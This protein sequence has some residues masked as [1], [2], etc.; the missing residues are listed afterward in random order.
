M[1]KTPSTSDLRVFLFMLSG[2]FL[3]LAL[4]SL[5]NGLPIRTWALV[6]ALFLFAF[7]IVKPYYAKNIYIVWMMLGEV[8][9]NFVSK[10]ILIILFFLLFTPIAIFL[11]I[12]N[13]DL[14]N[15]KMKPDSTTY[16]SVREIEPGS[17]KYQF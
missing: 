3:F 8:I 15:K 5:F 14:L 10:I 17:M 16:W 1:N 4:Y 13:K 11:K 2:V 7:A 12:F 6:V 9:G